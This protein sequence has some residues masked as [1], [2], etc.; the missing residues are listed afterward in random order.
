LESLDEHNCLVKGLNYRNAPTLQKD[1][2]NEKSPYRLE[3]AV[4]GGTGC[5]APP[6]SFEDGFGNR[7][8]FIEK[9]P[10]ILR[11]EDNLGGF[12]EIAWNGPVP[13]LTNSL[14]HPRTSSAR[15]PTANARNLAEIGLTIKVFSP[16]VAWML[17]TMALVQSE[18]LNTVAFRASQRLQQ[19]ALG[20]WVI[21]FLI[22]TTS[23]E[24]PNGVGDVM[25][26]GFCLGLPAAIMSIVGLSILSWSLIRFARA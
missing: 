22:T 26:A 21:S 17:L 9:K 19:V 14:A 12:A 11:V 16:L 2:L 20:L 3:V 1:A 24:G 13:I 18:S 5:C 7:I 23:P 15:G 4:M 8:D 10:D 6:R 25:F